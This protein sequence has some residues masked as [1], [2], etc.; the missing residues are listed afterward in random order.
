MWFIEFFKLWLNR[1]ENFEVTFKVPFPTT[2][3]M[4]L[5]IEKKVMDDLI[6]SS[7]LLEVAQKDF[8]E[9]KVEG[10]GLI[11]ATSELLKK[12]DIFDRKVQLAQ[13][14]GFKKDFFDEVREA[15]KAS[16]KKVFAEID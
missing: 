2:A 12:L 9:V 3:G 11:S 5:A 16:A 4:R 6:I 8:N 15:S 7:I 1:K 13:W 10:T 14:A